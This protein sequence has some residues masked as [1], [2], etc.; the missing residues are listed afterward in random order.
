MKNLPIIIIMFLVSCTRLPAPET[1][2]K[3]MGFPNSYDETWTAIIDVISD[4]EWPI[5][6]MEK[7]SGLISTDFALTGVSAGYHSCRSGGQITVDQTR[8][9][10]NVFVKQLS[11]K[12][13]NVRINAHV[14]G[15]INT[16]AGKTW[17]NCNSSG[18]LERELFE[19]V[20]GILENDIKKTM[21]I[22]K[23][24]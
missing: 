22:N 23:I 17:E 1:F 6:A 18:Q 11:E 4:S 14:E 24:W 7:Q 9:K 8:I 20:S 12:K 15:F 13:I 3:A 16:M 2:N 21:T 5:E 10:L 19:K